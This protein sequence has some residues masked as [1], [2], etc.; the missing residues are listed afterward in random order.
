M[1]SREPI[2]CD[3]RPKKHPPAD[4]TGKYV[5]IHLDQ[6]DTNPANVT[7]Q[8]THT[9]ALHTPCG[10]RA[11][12]QPQVERCVCQRACALMWPRGAQTE[13]KY[14]SARA[15]QLMNEPTF[16]SVTARNPP[17]RS[18]AQDN[19]ALVHRCANGSSSYRETVNCPNTAQQKHM[20][21]GHEGG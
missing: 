5:N 7:Q 21:P 16:A 15:Q 10:R 12:T 6:M 17:G 13:E 18:A 20:L 2:S 1:V 9:E 19:A 3:R 14:D 8:K 4:R 11:S